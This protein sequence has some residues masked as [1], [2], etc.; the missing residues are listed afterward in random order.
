MRSSSKK[1]SDGVDDGEDLPAKCEGWSG[2]GGVYIYMDGLYGDGGKKTN[3][4]WEEIY[5]ASEIDARRDKVVGRDVE[6]KEDDAYEIVQGND[7]IDSRGVNLDVQQ[8]LNAEMTAVSS[9]DNTGMERIATLL[10][11]FGI[12]IAN[13]FKYMMLEVHFGLGEEK[14]EQNDS[15]DRTEMYDF[16]L[17]TAFLI[18]IV[19]VARRATIEVCFKKDTCPWLATKKSATLPRRRR[20]GTLSVVLLIGLVGQT[21]SVVADETIPLSQYKIFRSDEVSCTCFLFYQS[22]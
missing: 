3:M 1:D 20:F 14:E 18:S 19:F 11:C 7:V 10:S 4:D 13:A 9:V 15:F 22:I 17:L 6:G 21:L 5:N 12:I 8:G 16:A 2:V